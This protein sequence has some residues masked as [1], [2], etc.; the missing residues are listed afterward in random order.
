MPFSHFKII[1]VYDRK[2]TEKKTDKDYCSCMTKRNDKKFM[3]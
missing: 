2:T 1:L 3:I